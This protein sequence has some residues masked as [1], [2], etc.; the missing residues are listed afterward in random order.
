[1]LVDWSVVH[2]NYNLLWFRCAVDPEFVKSP[3]QKV[4]EHNMVSASL[5]NLGRNNTVESHR[6]NHREWVTRLLLNTLCSLQKSHLNGQ[7]FGPYLSL[8]RYRKLLC[9]VFLQPSCYDRGALSLML[10]WHRV[11]SNLGKPFHQVCLNFYL[12]PLWQ[13]LQPRRSANSTA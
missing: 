9:F 11:T 6:C 3:M 10:L 1:M 12:A 7:A 2:Q 8:F 13:A 4:V 5:R